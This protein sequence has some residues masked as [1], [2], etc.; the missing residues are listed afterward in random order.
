VVLFAVI[1]VFSQITSEKRKKLRFESGFSSL[2]K[3]LA[4]FN[5]Y[6]FYLV[7]IFVLF[8]LEFIFLV[9]YVFFSL[10]YFFGFILVAFFII[11]GF[12]FEWKQGQLVWFLEKNLVKTIIKV[13]GTTLN[14]VFFFNFGRMLGFILII[15]ILTGLFLVMYYEPRSLTAFDSVQFIMF[16][17]NYG[18]FIRLLHFNGASFFFIC[19]YLHIFK[20]LFFISFNMLAVWVTGLIIFILLMM[21]AFLGYTL[22]WSQMAFWAGTVITSL[23]RV[24]PVFGK[25]L[26]YLIWAGFYL[27][28]YTLKFFFLLHY[29]IP[30]IVVV[31]VFFHLFFLHYYGSRTVLS[32]VRK[33]MFRSFYPFFWVKD[34]L[35]IVFLLFFLLFIL[36]YPNVLGDP[37]GNEEVNELVSPVHIVP[38]WYFLW[39]YAILR[40]VPSKL[41]GVLFMFE[42]LL[43]FFLLGLTSNYHPKAGLFNK[44]FVVC[45]IF[46]GVL[47]SW[48][49]RC[50]PLAP[51][52]ALSLISAL[53]YFLLILFFGLLNSDLPGVYLARFNKDFE[54]KGQVLRIL[55]RI[56]IHFPL[57]R[58]E[59]HVIFTFWPSLAYFLE[60]CRAW[61]MNYFI[62]PVLG[63]NINFI[64]RVLIKDILV[65]EGKEICY[66]IVQ[67]HNALYVHCFFVSQKE[68]LK[69][70][71]PWP[72]APSEPLKASAAG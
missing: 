27:N 69:I 60:S 56:D 43:V 28:S 24:I 57:P 72:E 68:A 2:G 38:E 6:F 44:F 21:E 65:P 8:D 25:K 37:L 59:V 15:Q 17:V 16:E 9:Y 14:L 62:S 66:F 70:A 22:V 47:L 36:A 64:N 58:S 67:E 11:L 5:L 34:L 3:I 4:S 20:A 33:I 7:V 42:G 49:G 30:F 61:E 1:L 51:F 71:M 50:E 13:L 48:L 52:V 45:F 19:L 23:L 41:I 29:I 26:V 40:A 55:R 31:L 46:N 39:A 12:L 63:L 18:W 53:M 32:F 10:S 35:N 54:P